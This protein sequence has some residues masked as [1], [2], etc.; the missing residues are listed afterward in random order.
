M[1]VKSCHLLCQRSVYLTQIQEADH[2][3]LELWE[4]C[5]TDFDVGSSVLKD[6]ME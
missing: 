3:M 4:D 6:L 2:L 5:L 1:F